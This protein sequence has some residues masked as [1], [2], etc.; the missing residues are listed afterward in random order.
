MRRSCTLLFSLILLT[1]VGTVVEYASYVAGRFLA[2][3]GVFR[4]ATYNVCRGKGTD[5][6][7]DLSRAARILSHCDI[8]GV[9]ELAGPD[10][11]GGSNQAQTLG[12]QLKM[13]WLYGANQQRWYRDCA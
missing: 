7:Q 5:G 9:N 8:I 3:K 2:G 10:I 11:W 13:G 1:L 6:I 4:V 12:N